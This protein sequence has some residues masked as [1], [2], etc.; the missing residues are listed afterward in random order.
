[1]TSRNKKWPK[2]AKMTSDNVIT[3]K[4]GKL[5]DDENVK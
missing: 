2:K 1:M 5:R 3:S 4:N